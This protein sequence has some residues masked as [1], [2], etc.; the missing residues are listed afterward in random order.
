MKC[1]MEDIARFRWRST[2]PSRTERTDVPWEEIPW[3]ICSGL[4]HDTCSSLAIPVAVNPPCFD[5]ISLSHSYQKG[6]YVQI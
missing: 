3:A 4:F 5:L 6:A 2:T 1:S